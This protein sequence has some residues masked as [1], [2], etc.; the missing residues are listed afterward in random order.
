MKFQYEH[1]DDGDTRAG[2][3]DCF[4]HVVCRL[5]F[6]GCHSVNWQ[7][8]FTEL[9]KWGIFPLGTDPAYRPPGVVLGTFP[10]RLS[11]LGMLYVPSNDLEVFLDWAISKGLP[12][13]RAD[14]ILAM[15]TLQLAEE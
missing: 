14:L 3:F 7:S 5:G 10:E 11:T 1:L 8:W 2:Q 13:E 12:R 9:L 6:D 4:C 15:C